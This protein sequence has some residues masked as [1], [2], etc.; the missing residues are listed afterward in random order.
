ME[1]MEEI[2]FLMIAAIG[3]AKSFIMNSITRAS[4]GQFEEARELLALSNEKIVAAHEKHFGLIQKEA[5][6][7]K[8]EL[9]LLFIHAED[10]LMTT[11]LL[12][13]L[14]TQLVIMYEKMYE[15]T[16]N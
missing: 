13:D 8:I 14:A 9:G 7:E 12:K 2:S 16:G 10:Q 11:S 1:G 5:Q 6:G 15:L 4:E 3:E